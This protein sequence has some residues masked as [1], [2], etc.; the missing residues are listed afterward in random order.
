MRGGWGLPS[1]I[2]FGRV[3]RYPSTRPAACARVVCWPPTRR[4]RALPFVLPGFDLRVTVIS[5]PGGAAAA[6]PAEPL[7]CVEDEPPAGAP[8]RGAA[9]RPEVARAATRPRWFHLTSRWG[10][11][12]P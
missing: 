10:G 6:L 11:P 7:D 2:T 1:G 12:L 4:L 3:P 9:L 8:G 5:A